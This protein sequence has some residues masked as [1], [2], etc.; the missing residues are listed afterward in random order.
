MPRPD[1]PPGER[2]YA[3]GDIHGRLDLFEQL[4]AL[5]RRD[6]MER[7]VARV[8]LILLGDLIDR[9]PQAADL[10][11]RC[12]TFAAHSPDF[13]VL[14]GNHEEMMVE[15]LGGDMAIFRSWLEHGGDA[16]LASWGLPEALVRQGATPELQSAA[17]DQI[18]AYTLAWLARLPLM[19]QVGN[20][21][22]VHAGI[23]PGV[24][25]S[26]QTPQDLLWIRDMFLRS[27]VDHPYLV[28]HGHSIE[29][30]RPEIRGSRLGVDTGA[31]R[32]GRL[33]AVGLQDD[34]YWILGTSAEHGTREEGA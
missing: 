31:Y 26:R 23:R 2:I 29:E 13:V 3:I 17:L 18:P 25:L 34:R 1:L 21:L 20:C 28:V 5:I 9:G 30:G 15:A 10:V 19:L 6:N 27:E 14:K 8:R 32:T 7:P 11:E 4:I 16:T 24:P 12:R 33:T 22:F